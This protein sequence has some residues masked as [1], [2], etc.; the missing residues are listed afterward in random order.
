MTY[1]IN[2]NRYTKAELLKY[3]EMLPFLN[4]PVWKEKIFQFIA[5]YLSEDPDIEVQ[6]SGTT[7]TPK[8]WK[9]SKK[10]MQISA[11]KTAGYFNFKKGQD[12]LLVLPVDY[13]A[14]KMMI[15]RAFEHQLNLVYYEP[16]ANF[17]QQVAKDETFYFCPITPMQA[18]ISF[19]DPVSAK[20][21]KKIEHVL[22]GGAPVDNELAQK[23]E[24]QPNQYYHSYGMTETLTHM[25]IKKLNHS[26]SNHFKVLENINI[27]KDDRG[28]LVADAPEFSDEPLK[29]ND[30]ID[31]KGKTT[32]EWL[33]RYDNVINSG[34]IKI[35][36]EQIEAIIKPFIQ[37]AF[38][39]THI[40]DE[41]LGEKMILLIESKSSINIDQ[42]K[43]Q[44]LTVL[45]DHHIP[46]E[47][48]VID[49]FERTQ[50][51]KIKRLKL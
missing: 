12:V 50:S 11:A 41:I 4:L 46:K 30:L 38:Y 44:L 26:S 40:S 21:I 42:L 2:D 45:K 5:D 9:V 18:K 22:L 47:I 51:G 32:F 23:I 20:K 29:T 1:L 39:L 15:V 3:A 34:G 16:Q 25:A 28:C 6:S 48:R 14:G 17:L 36:P 49:E 27:S 19:N 31:L 13:I 35:I 43:E 10:K 33:G 8:R 24:K 7:G 37:Q